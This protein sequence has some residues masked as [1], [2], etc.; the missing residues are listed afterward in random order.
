[1]NR[2]ERDTILG[3]VSHTR[4]R[5]RIR[6]H[7]TWG[8]TKWVLED[9]RPSDGVIMYVYGYYPTWAEAHRAYLS[10]VS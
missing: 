4:E 8:S 6:Q 10:Q 9:Y 1:M 5:Y 2:Q 7:E 3:L